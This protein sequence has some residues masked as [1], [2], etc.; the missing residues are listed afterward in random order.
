MKIK[1]LLTTITLSLVLIF[2]TAL[3]VF[4]LDNQ[5]QPNQKESKTITNSAT[6]T[7]IYESE[8]NNKQSQADIISFNKTIHGDIN[9]HREHDYY[10]LTILKDGDLTITGSMIDIPSLGEDMN[11]NFGLWL[12]DSSFEDVDCSV[13]KIDEVAQTS[14]QEL[15]IKVNAGT[16]YI[17]A[18]QIQNYPGTKYTFTTSFDDGSR[19][20]KSLAIDPPDIRMSVGDSDGVFLTA[21][22]TNGY[23][24]DVSK[25]ATWTS[26]DKTIATLEYYENDIEMINAIKTGNTTI[27]ASY[28]GKKAIAKV[29][30]TPELAYVSSD[31]EEIL[32]E[33]GK[34]QP[35]SVYA[36]Y[37]DGTEENV[38][39][40]IE[41]DPDDMVS[42]SNGMVKGIKEGFTTITGHYNGWGSVT[43][44]ARINPSFKRIK[45]SNSK[46]NLYVGDSE[47]IVL[48]ATDINN[49]ELDIEKYATWV[50]SKSS[51]VTVEIVD[52][53]VVITGIKKGSSIITGSFGGKKV[54]IK[55]TIK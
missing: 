39:K 20:L 36:I 38:S 35:I 7:D 43:I 51:V 32:V 10:K 34:S 52:E 21:T 28:G 50:S 46:V 9:K 6:L 47:N 25:T 33:I 16:Y 45:V 14:F 49:D 40:L 12:E 54:G 23:E 24:E 27:T 4:A 11:V 53:N 15:K 3:P 13:L 42:I 31:K 55:V 30:V 22:Y 26:G 17:D 5:G 1:K 37:D 29:K 44:K 8:P 48:T 18:Y 2:T 19:T 41:Y